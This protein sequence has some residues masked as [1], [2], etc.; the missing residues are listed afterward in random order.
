MLEAAIDAGEEQ[1]A[2]GP[3]EPEQVGLGDA[4]LARDVLGGRAVVA[5][6]GELPEADLDDLLAALLGGRRAMA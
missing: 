2:L 6:V 5:A 3:E 4:G 1:L